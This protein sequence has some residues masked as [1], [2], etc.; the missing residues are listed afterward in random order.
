[1]RYKDQSRKKAKGETFTPIALANFVAERLLSIKNA[2]DQKLRI[3][4]PS[5]GDGSLLIALIKKLKLNLDNVSVI[6]YD[7][8]ED[9]L[10][11]AKNNLFN[12]F[13]TINAKFEKKDFLEEV[14]IPHLQGNKLSIE[15][16]DLI[17]ANPP[18]VRTQALNENFVKRLAEKLNLKEEYSSE[19]ENIYGSETTKWYRLGGF[20]ATMLHHYITTISSA[21]GGLLIRP[22]VYLAY[23]HKIDDEPKFKLC[24]SFDIVMD[25]V[26]SNEEP[27]T[28]TTGLD[29]KIV[30]QIMN[31]STMK[32]ALEILSEKPKKSRQYWSRKMV[33][34]EKFFEHDEKY[35]LVKLAKYLNEI[36]YDLLDKDNAGIYSTK[37][38]FKQ[39]VVQ[40]YQ[41]YAIHHKITYAQSLLKILDILKLTGNKTIEDI[42]YPVE[43]AEV[44]N[45][46]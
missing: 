24:D 46:Q 38:V 27:L 5:V 9:S 1:M 25:C 45:K 28:F 35:D 18:Y 41:L 37:L 17:I 32:K 36:V 3:L 10:N 40:F 21:K 15:K 44:F 2:K 6:A 31:K 22:S 19:N 13:P 43:P 20:N 39:F 12:S 8:N 23:P 33:K 11:K 16:F 14:F 42:E 34:Y 26:Y 7:I 30:K 29:D 4:E